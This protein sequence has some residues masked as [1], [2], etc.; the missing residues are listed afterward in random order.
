MQIESPT[1][2]QAVT[3][4]RARSAELIREGDMRGAEQV[5]RDQVLLSGAQGDTLYDMHPEGEHPVPRG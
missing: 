3:A 5:Q 2:E 4:L 1:R